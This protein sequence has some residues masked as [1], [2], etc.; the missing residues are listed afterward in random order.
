M[1][2]LL[3]VITATDFRRDIIKRQSSGVLG[4]CTK[5]GNH[6][7]QQGRSDQG[8]RTFRLLD[9][10]PICHVYI[11][12][13]DSYFWKRLLAAGDALRSDA[14]LKNEYERCERSF[15]E[16]RYPKILRYLVGYTKYSIRKN[17]PVRQILGRAGWSDEEIDKQDRQ[18]LEAHTS[19]PHEI[20]TYACD[21]FRFLE[22]PAEIRNVIYEMVL[23]LRIKACRAIVTKPTSQCL[24]LTLTSHRLRNESRAVMYE[25]SIVCID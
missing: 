4:R 11:I 25:K 6:Q 19:K 20:S 16:G 1:D 21:T 22:L 10:K 12:A 15:A 13:E 8:K 23:P 9:I 2:N 18:Y 24:A 3:I 7:F 14:D 5:S 17:L